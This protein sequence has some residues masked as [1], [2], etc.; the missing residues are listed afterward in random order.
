LYRGI[1]T[2]DISIQEKC[3]L[4]TLATFADPDGSNIFPSHSTLA[5]CLKI[6]ESS[7]R[8][9]VASLRKKNYL[10]SEQ[11]KGYY[12][13]YRLQIP[14]VTPIVATMPAEDISQEEWEAMMQPPDDE[15]ATEMRMPVVKPPPAPPPET[16]AARPPATKLSPEEVLEGAAKLVRN[17]IK[18]Y[19]WYLK[20]GRKKG[21]TDE[22]LEWIFRGGGQTG[23]SQHGHQPADEP[24]IANEMIPETRHQTGMYQS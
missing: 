21:Y 4:Y 15:D 9:L 19:E 14:G 1:R 2:L 17:G 20:G 13:Q 8:R 23:S 22:Y 3:L 6:A 7:V 10:I 16:P 11:R 12:M 18:D 24:V 5:Q